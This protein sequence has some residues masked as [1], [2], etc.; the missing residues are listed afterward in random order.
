[1]NFDTFSIAA[2][3]HELRTV[4]LSGRV[5]QVI[6]INS[7]AFGFEIFYIGFSNGL[8]VDGME[9]NITHDMLPE[10]EMFFATDSQL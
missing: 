9:D 7:L 5:Q 4:I 10:G 8:L 1:M 6:Q 2:M 3:A